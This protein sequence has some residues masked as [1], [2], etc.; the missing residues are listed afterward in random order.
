MKP[1]WRRVPFPPPP[2]KSRLVY[3]GGG[4]GRGEGPQ[5]RNGAQ[6]APMSETTDLVLKLR[7]G[8]RVCDR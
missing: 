7:D 4:G 8:R 3:G 1:L 2:T 5:G 6:R